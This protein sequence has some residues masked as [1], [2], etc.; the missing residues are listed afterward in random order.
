M[1]RTTL[2][3]LLPITTAACG[4]ITPEPEALTAAAKADRPTIRVGDRWAFAC[5]E[6]SKTSYVFTVITSVDAAGAKGKSNGRPLILTPDL[7]EVQGARWSHTP[8]L[9]LYSFP[10][11]VGKKWSG[12]DDWVDQTNADE[13]SERV[14]VTVASYEKV[15]VPAGEFDA[16]RLELISDWSSNQV[17]AG[18]T[19]ATIWYAP[20]ARG[21]VKMQMRV[22]DEAQIVCE[23]TAM[24][25][26]P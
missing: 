7:N 12:T 24:Q 11:E 6:G 13:G 16:F 18:A 5:S 17:Y 10:L 3:L 20:A 25:L 8:E 21:Q 2:A 4:T 26:Q 1:L 9:K 14:N 23:M 15:R 19:S 22:Q